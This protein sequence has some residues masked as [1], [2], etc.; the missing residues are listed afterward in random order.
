M[1][2]KF[3]TYSINCVI[4]KYAAEVK[5]RHARK[6]DC[7][8]NKSNAEHGVQG[9]LK[10]FRKRRHAPTFLNRKFS[11]SLREY[12]IFFPSEAMAEPDGKFSLHGSG[13]TNIF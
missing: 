4:S 6:D 1:K 2:Q 11:A 13:A 9:N 3:I 5:S 8:V 7:L 12:S 10:N